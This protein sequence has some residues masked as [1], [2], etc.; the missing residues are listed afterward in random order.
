[1]PATQRRESRKIICGLTVSCLM[2]TQDQWC[3]IS[4]FASYLVY[5]VHGKRTFYDSYESYKLTD[6]LLQFL[7][8]ENQCMCLSC[9]SLSGCFL[10]VEVNSDRNYYNL[11]PL[12]TTF[13]FKRI[14][15]ASSNCGNLFL[16]SSCWIRSNILSLLQS[17]T[18]RCICLSQ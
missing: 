6:K 10:Y 2:L 17:N 5:A 15:L 11:G 16:F 8:E 12:H 14:V 18:C 13:N 3:W 9:C 1:M 4:T 7:P